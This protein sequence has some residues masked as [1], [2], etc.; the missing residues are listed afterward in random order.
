MFTVNQECREHGKPLFYI[1][2]AQS[3]RNL[4]GEE[5]DPIANMANMASLLYFSLP[6]IN[7]SGFYIYDGQEL[8]LGPFHGKPACVRIQMGKGVCGTS[9]F[10]RETLMI[11]NVHEFPGHIACDADSKSEI[12]IPLIKDDII[13]GVLDI[14]SPIYAR[15][16][17]D[18]KHGLQ[19]L[20]EI[21]QFATD[22]TLLVQTKR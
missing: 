13:I 7:W 4:L 8:V 21:L 15:F 16:D 19:Q 1:D 5:R 9:A 18:D 20:I 10:K 11:E 22:F 14:D 3:L 6:S 17:E 2:L 12:V